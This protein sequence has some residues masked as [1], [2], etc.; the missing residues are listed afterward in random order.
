MTMLSRHLAVLLCCLALPAQ[1]DTVWLS[2]GDRLTGS[3]VLLDGGKLIFKTRYAGRLSINWKDIDTLRSEKPLLVKRADSEVLTSERLEAAGTG[4]L[5]VVNGESQTI[6]LAQVQ[7]LMPPRPLVEDW[8]S[9]GNL[10]VK[11]KLERNEDKTDQLRL[12]GDT[13]ITHGSWRQLLHAEYEREIE[14]DEV[15]E[16]NWDLEYDLDRFFTDQWFWRVSNEHH[17]DEFDDLQRWR[18]FGTGPG[19]SFWNNELGRFE[20]IGRFNRVHVDTTQG[21]F[22]FDAYSLDWDFRRL[23]WGT[24]V[25]AYST[26]TLL[27][28][29]IS[30]VDYLFDGEFGLRYRLNEWARLSLLYELDLLASDT[31]NSSD[32]QFTFGV[33]VGW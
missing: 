17:R 31:D 20:L 29:T 3:I 16:N 9:E 33:G 15:S 19:Y 28:P 6:P 25:E 13:R 2:N 26:A 30:Q 4:M 22:E 7:Q 8:M 12:K 32:E 14:D 21:D 23:L 10:D 24:Q 11:L 1:A 27:Q 18:G 5:R